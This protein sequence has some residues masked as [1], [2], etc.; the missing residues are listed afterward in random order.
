MKP[1]ELKAVCELVLGLAE[2]KAKYC[3]H[4]CVENFAEQC[5][6]KLLPIVFPDDCGLTQNIADSHF[7][8]SVQLKKAIRQPV[9]REDNLTEE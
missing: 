1:E 3:H 9:G 8:Q 7:A 4:L 2:I 5:L 6:A